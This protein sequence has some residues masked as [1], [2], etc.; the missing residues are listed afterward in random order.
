LPAYLLVNFTIPGATVQNLI[1]LPDVPLT[2]TG[3]AIGSDGTFVRASVVSGV[4]LIVVT[5][6]VI[7]TIFCAGVVRIAP[8]R[9]RDR[10]AGGAGHREE[11]GRGGY[12]S[13]PG[14]GYHPLHSFFRKGVTPHGTIPERAQPPTQNALCR[15]TRIEPVMPDT[16]FSSR[17]V[18]GLLLSLVICLSMLVFLIFIVTPDCANLEVT[19]GGTARCEM[20]SGAY[21]FGA[22]FVAIAL[23]A[24]YRI[25]RVL[26]PGWSG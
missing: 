19:S 23:Y 8:L 4:V 24:G 16:D 26:F 12:P 22:A 21:L 18:F 11:R 10:G 17:E 13:R 25:C 14:R 3:D 1:I 2:V 5:T 9:P 6:V 20:E 7:L 15:E